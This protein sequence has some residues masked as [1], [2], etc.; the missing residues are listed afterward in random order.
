MMQHCPSIPS[1]VKHCLLSSQKSVGSPSSARYFEQQ[2]GVHVFICLSCAEDVV[3]CVTNL[4]TRHSGWASYLLFP[5][6][7]AAVGRH[8][9]SAALLFL[10]LGPDLT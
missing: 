2:D 3:F 4:N 8:L 1:Q 10:S 7:P 6:G 5:S 9:I